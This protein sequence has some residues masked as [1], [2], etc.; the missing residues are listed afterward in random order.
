MS[1]Q[2][3]AL[4]SESWHRVAGQ[5]LR[6]RPS[7][8]IRKQSFRGESWHIA[9]DGF[10][11]QFF[12]FRPEAYDIVARLDGTQ[13][14][15][16]IWMGCLERNP[17][18]APGQGEVVTL[19][20]QL[21][22]ANLIVSELPADTRQ[23]FE[24]HKKRVRQTIK[25]QIFGVFFLRIPL[26][27]PDALLNRCW[28][29]LRWL[30]TPAAGVLWFIVVGLGLAAVFGQWDRARDQTQGII[31]PSNL[32]LLYVA[33]TITKLVHEF[34]HA[35]CVKKFG[36]EVHAMG[37][38][39][40]V[41]TPIPYVD[42]TAAWALRERW[43]RIA[44]G[45]AG[46][47]PEL[48]VAGVAALIWANTGPGVLNSVCY[49][50]MIVASVSTIVFNLNPLLRF[51][52]YYVLA[53]L[54]D[55]PN[56][57]PRSVR[58]LLHLVER[59]A[60]GGTFSTTSARST[61]DS[62]WL[63][64]YGVASWIYRMFVTISIIL[65][66]ADRY[67]GIGLLA[68]LV[69]FIGSILM[70]TVGAF[71]YLAREPRIE[72]VRKRAWAVSA[73]TLA[74]LVLLLAVMP[75]PRHFRASGVVRAAGSMV[76][77]TPASGWVK[78]FA[79]NSHQAIA[80]QQPL[81]HLESP[82]M[83][84]VIASVR[85]NREQI[86][87]R[88]RDV[89][90]NL[91]S[92]IAPMRSRREAVEMQLAQ[93]ERDQAALD[94][95]APVPGLWVSPR[96]GELR[97]IW[98]PRGAPIGDIIGDGKDWEFFAVVPQEYAGELFGGGLRG[99]D[100]RFRGNAGSVLPVAEWKVVPGRQ[101]VLPSPALGWTAGGPVRVRMD[102]AQGRHSAEPFFLVVARIERPVTAGD[103]PQLLWQGRTGF[104]RFDLPWSPL[105]VQWVRSFRQLLQDRY[106]I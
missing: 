54:T 102:D 55:S 68:G 59:Y 11:N 15:E 45:L 2:Q 52:G 106:Q 76:V 25:S 18:R 12:R 50:A 61:A 10:T 103:D 71:K 93:L 80:A 82:E 30:F 21:Y 53:D 3:R 57:Q 88:E 40:L 13:T 29:V 48:F 49:N 28:P 73:A 85:A 9:K 39:L 83:A 19:L 81:A 60:F 94:I 105:L 63:G 96:S 27:D 42:A 5:R 16:E 99:A 56:L 38:T 58:H 34:G 43:K 66:V 79:V 8:T 35:A 64:I 20:A 23:L 95:G 90:H 69:T 91:P 46:M 78:T 32:F 89:L 7:V 74:V 65:L 33:F 41:F 14:M 22:Q 77:V 70:P 104:V 36:G 51:D 72:R 47:I 87:A 98:L 37:I 75:F 67:F 100:I 84:L 1:D 4:F 6:L 97:D 44:V 92:A 86:L 17:D 26:Y 24:R 101:D 31:D 62:W